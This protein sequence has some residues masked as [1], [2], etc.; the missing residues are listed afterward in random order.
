MPYFLLG[1]L[2]ICEITDA[3]DGYLAR[4][5]NQV[6]DVGKIIDP[7]ADT[8]T[9]ISVFF[10]FTQGMVSV[11][12]LIV[13]ILLYR[14]LAVSALRTLCALRGYALAA[15][16][17]GKLKAILQA[18][19]CIFIVIVMIPYTLGY[20]SLDLLQNISLIS[21]SLVALYT[22]VTLFDYFYSN[23]E[24]IKKLVKS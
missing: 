3:I 14:E 4:K 22:L 16:R 11:P 1:I 21:V 7:M 24:Y 8:I 15:R 18:V 10:T 23:R 12:L 2:L 20:I 13:F 17:S 5:K 9:H 6:T 19:V